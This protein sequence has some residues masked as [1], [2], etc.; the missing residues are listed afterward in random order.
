ML[1]C[2][3]VDDAKLANFFVGG[4]GE[5]LRGWRSVTHP[6][7]HMKDLSDKASGSDDDYQSFKARINAMRALV[8]AE[9]KQR[10]GTP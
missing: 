3:N 6:K 8:D 5:S 9:V 10:A 2:S 7:V 4:G 1:D